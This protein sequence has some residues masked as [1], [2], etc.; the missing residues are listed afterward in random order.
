MNNEYNDKDMSESVVFFTIV[1]DR[2]YYPV[3]TPKL[4]SSFKKFHREIELVVFRQDLIDRV[5]K[6]KGVNFYTAKPTFAKLLAPHYDLVVNIDADSVI[7]G[8]LEAVLA[9]D[10]E[11]GAAWN[12]NDYE[13]MSVENVSEEMFVQAGLVAS[14]NKL[15]WDIWEHENLK[16]M[17]YP[18]RENSTLNLI[19]YN[20]P[21]V[22][23]MKR[24][25]FDKDKDYYGCKSLNRE[26][27]FYLGNGRVM[28]RGEQVLCYHHAKGGHLPKLVY[29][30]MGFP[31]EV[32]DFMNF[33]SSY[34]TSERY[35]A[36]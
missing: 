28:C 30:T 26:K 11:V 25:I 34:G 7:L 1:D 13:N 27:E 16:A 20:D 36:I 29:E 24:K 35:A 4:I 21:D 8:R 17:K 18:A 32:V 6:E 31:N 19:W 3:G 23:K 22:S 14:R 15:F 33:V 9:Q 5:F 10:Y 12:F 2:Y